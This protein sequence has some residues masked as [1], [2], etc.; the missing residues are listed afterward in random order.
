MNPNEPPRLRTVRRLIDVVDDGLVL[1]LAGRRHLVGAAADCKG[2][3]GID[4]DDDRRE[5][6]VCARGRRIGARLGVPA[7][8]SDR[9]LQAMIAD[10]RRQQGLPACSDDARVDEQAEVEATAHSAPP[11]ASHPWLRWF[12]PPRRWAPVFRLA[13][14]AAQARLLETL[15]ARVLRAPLDQGALDLLE[16]R[17]IGIEV[18][19][20]GLRWVVTVQRRHLQVA[21]QGDAEAT[22]RGDAVDLMLLA[23][24][25]EDADTLFFQRRLVLTG[26]VEL[27]L[28]ARNLLDQLPWGDVPL[29]QRIV[30]HRAA[31]WA[32]AARA[33]WRGA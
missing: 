19:D 1:L 25:R 24:R 11:S 15:F 2:A 31:G 29:A 10:A 27:G 16:G 12:P 9:L 33:A 14:A 18:I 7:A 22:V 4:A 30:L 3:A 6:A 23:S 32:E 13:P 20:L 8:S 17:R 28:T 26:D 21:G 5:R